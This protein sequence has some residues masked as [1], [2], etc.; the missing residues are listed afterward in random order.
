MLQLALS[1][2]GLAPGDVW[3]GLRTDVHGGCVGSRLGTGWVRT[4]ARLTALRGGEEEAARASVCVGPS[5]KGGGCR[6][7]PAMLWHLCYQYLSQ[8]D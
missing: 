6:L 2:A 8:P 4:C 3:D 1:K 7:I 5:S